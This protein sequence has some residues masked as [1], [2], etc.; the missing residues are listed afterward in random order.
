MALGVEKN[1][2]SY[3]ATITG[4][5]WFNEIRVLNVDDDPGYAYTVTAGVNLANLLAINF[6]LG[7]TSPN[8]YNLDGRFGTRQTGLNWDVSATLNMH[9]FFNNF[10]ANWFSEEWSNFLTLPLTFRHTERI[11]DP[12]YYPGTDIAIDNAMQERYNQVYNQTGNEQEATTAS[13]NLKIESQTLEVR[14]EFGVNGMKF[15]FPGNNYLL[16]NIVNRFELSFNG[17]IGTY[18]DVT[19]ENRENFAYN[20][21]VNFKPDFALGDD[22][23]LSIGKWL[24]L[25]DDYK[26]AK[27]YFALPFLPLAP[28][29]S[30]NFA[31]SID[32]N[33]TREESKQRSL[34]TMNP[35]SRVFDA[36]RGF[37]FDWK[38]IEGW[39]VDLSGN[40][41]YRVGSDLRPFETNNDSLSTQRPESEVLS[42]IFFNDALI[43]FGRDLDYA[44]TTSFNPRFNIPF[45]K[46]FLDLT[47]SY[48][49]TYGWRNPNV[50]DNAVGYNVQFSNN[51]STTANFKLNELFSLISGSETNKSRGSIGGNNDD[52]EGQNIL[53]VFKLFK[54][55]IPDA[56]S[57]TFN[58]TN[59]RINPAIQ[60]RPGFGNFWFSFGS[61]ESAGPSRAYQLGLSGDPGKRIPNLSNVQ[62]QF[63]LANNIV[64]S[65]TIKPIF[66]DAIR[67]NLSFK[68]RWGFTNTNTYT[69][70]NEGLLS[71]Q[72]NKSNS[73]NNAYSIFFFPDAEDFKYLVV[74][75]PNENLKNIS[76][77]FEDGLASFPF[78]NWNM[79]ITGVEKFPFFGQFASS[80]TIENNFES[81]YSKTYSVN[82]ADIEIP[83][84]QVVKQTFSPLFGMNITFKEAFSGNLTASFK[85]NTAKTLTLV[86]SSNLIQSSKTSDW[87]ISAS[88]SKAGFE[89]PFFGLSL[90]NDIA[91]SLSVSKTANEPIDYRFNPGEEISDKLP[92]NGSSV[93]TINPS[94]QYSLSSK[95]QMQLFYKYI[96]TEPLNA[97]F[98]TVPRTSNEGGLNIR[99]SIQ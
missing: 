1:R 22:Y 41:S 6:S 88:F 67:M 7:K 95:V 9:K 82:N 48:N 68:K 71:F 93:F 76:N 36:H 62:D 91:F 20:G 59:T 39:I 27:L 56:V 5:V 45:I 33:R 65:T 78:P 13:N 90:Q 43:N 58:Q 61:D 84:I 3:N 53:D 30:N 35:I 2:N 80:V 85:I 32:F 38:F 23:H 94:I 31:G 73:V 52:R 10:F 50:Q 28:L 64:F 54:G 81:E 37:N 97:T 8:F 19:Y 98:T 69:T 96:R 77:S 66:P 57:V 55:F 25:G 12:K 63:Q 11:I 24:N 18:R 87:S 92:G 86:P 46:K 40:Y 4:S 99:I 44:Q 17:S 83:S 42:S 74:S 47:A 15:T 70:N 49:V 89:I 21:G 51:A 60:G 26:D 75:D 79:T 34:N 72:T 16:K 29:F 14:N